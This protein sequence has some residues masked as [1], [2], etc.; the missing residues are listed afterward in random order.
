MSGED[1]PP[2]FSIT[3]TRKILLY[4]D[5]SGKCWGLGWLH[6][7]MRE[8]ESGR[9]CHVLEC[10]AAEYAVVTLCTYNSVFCYISNYRGPS[11]NRARGKWHN[12]STDVLEG[13]NVLSQIHNTRNSVTSSQEES[14]PSYV[15]KHL[16]YDNHERS[17]AG[18]RK[19]HQ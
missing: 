3:S 9:Q 4:P 5:H 18:L 16:L 6:W 19:P 13:S 7:L 8:T 2:A 1:W 14:H 15:P 17:V 12:R 10:A 11:R